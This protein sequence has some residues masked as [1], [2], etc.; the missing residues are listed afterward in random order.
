MGAESHVH[1]S[2]WADIH[3]A[4]MSVEM[5]SAMPT[6]RRM[7]CT[8]TY[9]P[10]ADTGYNPEIGSVYLNPITRYTYK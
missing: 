5:P 1:R 7:V 3:P 10:T 6:P 4:A 9:L 2:R 8:Y